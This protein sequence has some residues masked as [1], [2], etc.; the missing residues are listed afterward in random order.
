MRKVKKTI[1]EYRLKKSLWD[2]K[3]RLRDKNLI[4][5]SLGGKCVCCGY[6]ASPY[7]LDCHHLDPKE[8]VTTLSQ[9]RMSHGGWSAMVEEL[10]KC[11]L[12]CANCH[13]EVEHDGRLIPE[14]ATRF[15]EEFVSYG[16]CIPKPRRTFTP[17]NCKRCK[18]LYTPMYPHTKYCS[19]ACARANVPKKVENRPTKEELFELISNF[20]WSEVGRRYAVSDNCIRKWARK[21]GLL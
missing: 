7:A 16:E 5:S 1:D 8:K 19:V 18:S 2:K 6:S 20:S 14:N 15:N 21:Y 9:I 10:R 3:R 11:V 4:I 13:R 12:V 17:K